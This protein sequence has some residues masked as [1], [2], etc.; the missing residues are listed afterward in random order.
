MTWIVM[1][2]SIPGIYLCV[3]MTLTSMS[4][5]MAVMVINLYNRGAKTRRAPK[6][7]RILALKWISFVL[8]MRHD[9]ERLVESINLVYY[10]YALKVYIL[11]NVLFITMEFMHITKITYLYHTTVHLRYF[12]I[13][14]S[15]IS[16]FNWF[17][18][19]FDSGKRNW[20]PH[21]EIIV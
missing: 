9:L 20:N 10:L 6:W 5:I 2:F 3:V 7:I 19:L 15:M 14:S 13:H 16:S 17:I 1:C 12:Y 4:V 21:S 8:R 18:F 11:W